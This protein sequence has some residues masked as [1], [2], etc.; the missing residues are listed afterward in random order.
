[1]LGIPGVYVEPSLREAR[2]DIVGSGLVHSEFEAFARVLYRYGLRFTVI[3]T[4]QMQ[5]RSSSIYIP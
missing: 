3:H 2:I 1:M 5:L 4:D